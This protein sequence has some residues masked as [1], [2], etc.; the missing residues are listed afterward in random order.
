MMAVDQH[1][2]THQRPNCISDFKGLKLRMCKMDSFYKGI[3]CVTRGM[4]L[5]LMNNDRAETMEIIRVAHSGSVSLR[6]WSR[7]HLA[8]SY[9]PINRSS[10]LMIPRAISKTPRP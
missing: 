4:V 5:K 3:W 1:P 2:F 6:N 7:Y 8:N 9:I 10:S